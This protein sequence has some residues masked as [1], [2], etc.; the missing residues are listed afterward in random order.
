MR[1][2]DFIKAI[3]ISA[4]GWPL[5]ARAQ[6]AN[7][8]RRIGLLM[9]LPEKDPEAQLR[10]KAIRAELQ[11]RGWTEGINIR[12]DVRWQ[13]GESELQSLANQLVALRP[14]IIFAQSTP[15][16]LALLR[17]T[18]TTPIVFVQR[19]IPSMARP[20]GNVTGFSNFEPSIGGKWLELLKEVAPQLTRVAVLFNPET[21]PYFETYSRSIEVA[22]P[23]YSVQVSAIPVR[24]TNEIES[25][26]TPLGSEPGNGLI[27]PPDVFTSGHRELINNL[28]LR[29]RLPTAY[30]FPYLAV[31]GGLLS[32]GPD[33][34]A[35]Y[36]R[37]MSYV[38]RILR[39]ESPG[40]LPIQAPTEFVLAINVRTAKALGLTVPPTLL[41]IANEVV[42]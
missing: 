29:Y 3:A 30:S 11:Q 37:S 36:R 22:A 25:A 16:V 28:A 12:I 31:D 6:Q 33:V 13:G 18:R 21:A 14:D 19:L 20:G 27:F 42:E 35:M 26:L 34:I 10:L 5:A 4:A 24:N 17:E 8:P 15:A 1:R 2:R 7:Q 32:Y 38:D 41:A 23:S 40:D 39:G 9:S